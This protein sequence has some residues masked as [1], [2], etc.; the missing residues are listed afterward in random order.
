VLVE[1]KNEK[2]LWN[3]VVVGVS[4]SAKD[5]VNGY[6][7]HYKGWSSR[8]D[9]WVE[10]LRVVEPNENNLEVQVSLSSASSFAMRSRGILLT[11]ACT[12]FQEELREELALVRTCIPDPLEGM[13]AHKFLNADNRLRGPT[14]IPDLVKV[15][16]VGPSATSEETTFG[17]LKAALLMI[18]AA[19]PVGSVDDS[20]KGPWSPERASQWRK[21]V[22]NAAGPSS[23]MRCAILLEESISQEYMDMKFS[24]LLSCLPLRWKAIKEASV[25]SL[26]L[27]IF[28]FDRGINYSGE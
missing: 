14:T 6:R 8:F 7:V 4:T 19:L 11:L 3:A 21:L 25:A 12:S 15:A 9:E 10:P 18:D 1:S 5:K 2:L 27:R 23:L 26:A 28:L 13:K 22:Q 16:K 20:G 24:H 17:I